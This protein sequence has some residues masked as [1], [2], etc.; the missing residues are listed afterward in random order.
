M[1]VLSVSYIPP[2]SVRAA[3]MLT[4]LLTALFALWGVWWFYRSCDEYIRLQLLRC[5]G[6]TAVI[7]TVCSLA[8]FLLELAGFPRQSMLWLNLFGW[9]I[10]NAQVLFVL[11]RSG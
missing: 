6:S 8:Y 4:P 5:A 2:G 11:L 9:S 3:V 1:S 7:V 10:F